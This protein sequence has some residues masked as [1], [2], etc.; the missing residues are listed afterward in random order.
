MCKV[1][2][3]LVLFLL[4]A[5]FATPAQAQSNGNSLLFKGHVH[6]YYM[7]PSKGFFKKREPVIF[8]GLLD[9]VRAI[10]LQS[11]SI[12]TKTTTNRFGEFEVLLDLDKLY[13]L[14]IS[15]PGYNKNVLYLD[16]RGI[17]K[18]IKENGLQFT[19]A[20]FILNRFRQGNDENLNATIGRLYYNSNK[21]YFD[22]SIVKQ[23]PKKSGIFKVQEHD[24]LGFLMKRAITK[25]K[26]SFILSLD[27]PQVLE[28]ENRLE[29]STQPFTTTSREKE[30]T[31]N[32]TIHTTFN[33]KPVIGLQNFDEPQLTAREEEIQT[34]RF[35]LEVDKLI[36]STSQDSILI[37]EREI[38]IR[39][40]ELEIEN[41]IKLI[42]LQ[43]SEI[44]AQRLSVQLLIGSLLLLLILIFVGVNYYRQKSRSNSL[45]ATKNK[46]ILESI[47]YAK[48]IQQ[49]I[50][51]KEKD[52][53]KY[54]PYSFVYYQPKDIVS[55]DFY[56]FTQID[57]KQVLAAIDCTGHGVPGAFMSLIGNTLLNE[58]INEKKITDPVLILEGLHTR[59]IEALHQQDY[60]PTYDGMEMSL[61]VI[62]QDKHILE[63]SGAM[64]SLYLVRDNQ[65]KVIRGDF[66]SIGGNTLDNGKVK[67]APFTKHS[68]ELK[69]NTSFYLFTDGYP[70]Q[71]GGA[72][73]R[74]F[75]TNRFKT[76]L[77]NIQKMGMK[78]QKDFLLETIQEWKGNL[79]K[80]DDLLIIGVKI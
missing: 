3:I 11:D 34:A 54:L 20:E 38:Q 51:V 64:S 58:I 62:D 9:S 45:L 23:P 13:Q 61:C 48:R 31:S 17:P 12:Y 44:S 2:A 42:A 43:K 26:D 4:I 33:L 41:A 75:N 8:E 66:R 74:K 60:S 19:G 78:Q 47:Y 56:W 76:L 29:R 37:N 46:K 53:R 7:D 24:N 80:L 71:F 1:S 73:N 70:D 22:F 28:E 14:E 32:I 63:Y 40:A 50:L 49:A 67:Y 35:R 77:V 55:G 36:A 30:S 52:I 57:G 68:F 21:G 69:K 39:T 65:L 72:D 59:V 15:K 6:G 10:V 16:T 18:D 25:N 79:A 5:G 27:Q